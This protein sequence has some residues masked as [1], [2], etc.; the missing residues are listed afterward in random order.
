[1]ACAITAFS[2]MP[3]NHGILTKQTDN[4][5]AKTIALIDTGVSK[6]QKTVENISVI[7]KSPYDD[8]SHG[9]S[10]YKIIKKENPDAK[11]LSIKALNK[12]GEGS[13]EDV[14][15]AI[16]IAIDKKVDIINLSMA[17]VYN[18]DNK[19]FVDA[20][21]KASNSGIT[22]VMAA[23]NAGRPVSEYVAGKVDNDVIVVG[24]CEKNAES[25][26]S[27]FGKEIDYYVLTDSTSPAT[28]IISGKLSKGK[29]AVD[30][31][32]IYSDAKIERG[33]KVVTNNYNLSVAA[34]Y[35]LLVKYHVNG[36]TIADNPHNNTGGCDHYSSYTASAVKKY[37]FKTSSSLVTGSATKTGTYATFQGRFASTTTYINLHNVGTFG[38]SRTGYHITGTSA[39]RT[40]STGGNLINQDYSSSSTTNAATWNRLT[41][42]AAS[43]NKT[44]TLYVNWI[45]DSC[46]VT[47]NKNGGTGGTASVTATYNSN[48]PSATMPTRAGYKFEGYYD[49]AT[50]G[51]QYYTAAGA[52]ARTWNKAGTGGKT[53]YARWTPNTY[54]VN[55]NAN[56]GSGTMADQ[57]VTY[58]SG[59]TSLNSNTFTKTGYNFDGWAISYDTA[60]GKEYRKVS[61]GADIN[62]DLANAT[63]DIDVYALWKSKTV[64]DPITYDNYLGFNFSNDIEFKDF[65]LDDAT[66]TYLDGNGNTISASNSPFKLSHTSG[67]NAAN[68]YYNGPINF[69]TGAAPDELGMISV[70]GSIV[71]RFP[72]AAVTENGTKCDVIVKMTDV[73][74]YA[75]SFIDA[76]A[77][78]YDDND[79]F[80]V[81]LCY[82]DPN[83]GYFWSASSTVNEDATHHTYADVANTFKANAYN[84]KKFEVDIVA[85]SRSGA[86]LAGKK[87]V[88]GV[89][90]IDSL[91]GA[92][93][94]SSEGV[95]QG[96]ESESI[97]L[98]DNFDSTIFAASHDKYQN[99]DKQLT[100][101]EGNDNGP[102]GGT[103]V[104]VDPRFYENNPDARIGNNDEQTYWSGV[105]L[106]TTDSDFSFYS[107]TSDTSS[108]RLFE[109]PHAPIT[110]SVTHGIITDNYGYE[111]D[112]TNSVMSLDTALKVDGSDVTYNYEPEPGYH[113]ES[114]T[115]TVGTNGVTG[116]SSTPTTTDITSSAPTSTTFNGVYQNPLR[117]VDVDGSGTADDYSLGYIWPNSYALDVVYDANEFTIV[118]DKNATNATGTMADQTVD[119]ADNTPIR[120]NA[121]SRPGYR[122]IG[123]SATA[124]NA[125]TTNIGVVSSDPTAGR[126][127]IDGAVP[128]HGSTVTLKAQWEKLGLLTVSKDVVS[129][130][131]SDASLDFTFTVDLD[132]LEANETYDLRAD[133]SVTDAVL[134]NVQTD[135]NGTA[136]VTFTL[137]DGAS[138]GLLLPPGTEY[139][140]TETEN[141]SFTTTSTNSSG[142]ISSTADDVT[143]VFTNTRKT[144]NIR[145][146]KHVSSN[147]AS[148]HSSSKKFNF[149]VTL[150]ETS[151]TKECNGIQFTNGVSESIA[152]ADGE[153]INITG[154]PV[155]TTY[156]VTESADS[157]F[158][159]TSTNESGTVSFDG[160]SVSF[161]N[162]RKTGTLTLRKQVYND[163][164][165]L[166]YTLPFTFTITLGDNTFN[167]TI[168]GVN[169]VNGVATVQRRASQGILTIAGLPAGIS[170]TVTEQ[171]N[172]N[173][174]TTQTNATGTILAS[175]IRAVSFAN[176][177]DPRPGNLIIKKDIDYSD[178]YQEGM[179][180]QPLT[181]DPNL[182]NNRDYRIKVTLDNTSY[183]VYPFN[184]GVAYFTVKG[185]DSGS[186]ANALNQEI[187]TDIPIGTKY[188]VEEVEL[189][190]D[191]HLKDYFDI[192]YLKNPTSDLEDLG[193]DYG[194]M[195]EGTSGNNGTITTADQTIV[196]VNKPKLVEVKV[197][198]KADILYPDYNPNFQIVNEY[199]DY[200]GVLLEA[201]SV[202]N[203]CGTEPD[204]SYEYTE[205]AVT[206]VK[207]EA[208]FHVPAIYYDFN[209]DSSANIK[210][211]ELMTSYGYYPEDDITTAE[212]YATINLFE[213]E[214]PGPYAEGEYINNY[215]YMD[216]DSTPY[217]DSYGAYCLTNFNNATDRA[218]QDEPPSAYIT[219]VATALD[220]F[221][222]TPFGSYLSTPIKMELNDYYVFIYYKT[223]DGLARGFTI[224]K[225]YNDTPIDI[226]F[227]FHVYYYTP[228]VERYKLNNQGSFLNS[229][230]GNRLNNWFTRYSDPTDLSSAYNAYP[231]EL[232]PY[233]PDPEF[234]T[235]TTD[236]NNNGTQ[237][238]VIPPATAPFNPTVMGYTDLTSSVVRGLLS[239]D[240][241]SWF[242]TRTAPQQTYLAFDGNIVRSWNADT[243]QE[244]RNYGATSFL[245]LAEFDFEGYVASR[246]GVG[247]V[248]RY[249]NVD[250]IEN[251]PHTF[252]KLQI[253]K[254]E[255][256]TNAEISS[257]FA[258]RIELNSPEGI[259]ALPSEASNESGWKYVHPDGV[260]T[261]TRQ[262]GNWSY[263]FTVNG[264][265]YTTD[266][267]VYSDPYGISVIE[268]V[269]PEGYSIN[270]TPQEDREHSGITHIDV[271]YNPFWPGLT[272]P[273]YYNA[274]AYWAYNGDSWYTAEDNDIPNNYSSNNVIEGNFD[275]ELLEYNAFTN[276]YSTQNNLKTITFALVAEDDYINKQLSDHSINPSTYNGQLAPD[277]CYGTCTY[278]AQTDEIFCDYGDYSD[279]WSIME[280]ATDNFQKPRK[281]YLVPMI[282]T[283]DANGISYAKYISGYHDDFEKITQDVDPAADTGVPGL[284]TIRPISLYAGDYYKEISEIKQDVEAQMPNPQDMSISAYIQRFVDICQGDQSL[285]FRQ[286][287][288]DDDYQMA[289]SFMNLQDVGIVN[290]YDEFAPHNIQIS[291]TVT[292]EQNSL[293]TFPT[294]IQITGAKPN[295]TYSINYVTGGTGQAG[296]ITTDTN[297]AGSGTVNLGN[298]TTVTVLNVPH[299]AKYKVTETNGTYLP[300]VGVKKGT[301]GWQ[302]LNNSNTTSGITSLVDANGW[303]EL[304][305]DNQVQFTNNKQINIT[306]NKSWTDKNGA[307]L[308]DD[309]LYENS[310]VDVELYREQVDTI[311]SEWFNYPISFA[312]GSSYEVRQIVLPPPYTLL[313]TTNID[314][315]T[316]TDP[317]GIIQATFTSADIDGHNTVN[318]RNGYVV[319]YCGDGRFEIATPV[320]MQAYHPPVSGIDVTIQFINPVEVHSNRSAV[321]T[322]TLND[323]NSWSTTFNNLI[324]SDGDTSNYRYIV[325]EI[326]NDNELFESAEEEYLVPSTTT[327][328]ASV[329]VENKLK[330][331]TPN[332]DPSDG[333]ND[334]AELTKTAEVYDYEN[335]IYNIDLK[336][337]SKAVRVNGDIN[338][339]FAQSDIIADLDDQLDPAFYAVD[340]NGVPLE[341]GDKINLDGSRRTATD[342]GPYGIYFGDNLIKWQNQRIGN[343]A[344]ADE[345]EWHGRVFAKAKEDFMGGNTINTNEG[346]ALLTPKSVA[347]FDSNGDI[348]PGTSYPLDPYSNQVKASTP[349]VNV[350]E[351]LMTEENPTWQFVLND[352]VDGDDLKDQLENLLKDVKVKQVVTDDGEMVYPSAGGTA[353]A[354]SDNRESSI[355]AG[356]TNATIDLSDIIG[357][358]TSTQLE[359][360]FDGGT[361]RIPYSYE[362]HA[363]GQFEI[364]LSKLP[365]TLS[366]SDHPVTT[367]D[368]H[369]QISVTY[370]PTVAQSSTE[371]KT[372]NETTGE[373]GATTNNRT[374]NNMHTNTA[375]PLNLQ[376]LKR[377]GTTLAPITSGFDFNLVDPANSSNVITGSAVSNGTKT[378]SNIPTNT[379]G[380]WYVNEVTTPTGFQQIPNGTIRATIS[381]GSTTTTYP[382]SDNGVTNITSSPSITLSDTGNTYI[383]SSTSSGTSTSGTIHNYEITETTFTLEKNWYNS[384]E[385][386]MGLMQS[387]NPL[388]NPSVFDSVFDVTVTAPGNSTKTITDFV[389]NSE[390]DIYKTVSNFNRSYNQT[391]DE[392]VYTFK[393]RMS[394]PDASLSRTYDSI[395]ITIPI[396][397]KVQVTENMSAYPDDMLVI[398]EYGVYVRGA[399]PLFAYDSGNVTPEVDTSIEELDTIQ[400]S[401]NAMT[402]NNRSLEISKELPVGTQN[403]GDEFEFEIL[404]YYPASETEFAP[405]SFNPL[406]ITTDSTI[407][408]VIDNVNPIRSAYTIDA[409]GLWAEYPENPTENPTILHYPDEYPDTDSYSYRKIELLETADNSYIDIPMDAEESADL[410]LKDFAGQAISL[411]FK[412]KAGEHLTLDNLPRNSYAIIGEKAKSGWVSSFSGYINGDQ[413]NTIEAMNTEDDA[414]LWTSQVSPIEIDEIADGN[415]TWANMHIPY[416][417]PELADGWVNS[418]DT[419][420]FANG[421]SAVTFTNALLEQPVPRHNLTIGKNVTGNLGDIS[422]AFNMT[423][424]LTGLEPNATYQIVNA[425]DSPNNYYITPE[426]GNQSATSITA[427]SNGEINDLEFWI[428]D[429]GAFTIQG[430]PEN[431]TVTFAE[432]ANNH[433]PHATAYYET[434]NEDTDAIIP[435]EIVTA[436]NPTSGF[437]LELQSFELE[438][439]TKIDVTNLRSFRTVTGLNDSMMLLLMLIGIVSTALVAT[440]VVTRKRKKHFEA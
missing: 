211:R 312:G 251:D 315:I 402:N 56:G 311:T 210:V 193:Q 355:P 205:T 42:A 33:D 346:D 356:T 436:N 10:M 204:L 331:K 140:I 385:Y 230:F 287:V 347:D 122:F 209:N 83:G 135:S 196:V 102:N 146:E 179:E 319:S 391:N 36:G 50:G 380:Y 24:N 19:C 213:D 212:N 20:V 73:K 438:H 274:I 92:E 255:D 51:T 137:R 349:Y 378:F 40:A 34:T 199:L 79:D 253:L 382:G 178:F 152:L 35:Y 392:T 298:G 97:E 190:P 299:A 394:A 1:M 175:G 116:G 63:G 22:V 254:Y 71:M 342:T 322:E 267:L 114:V 306:V 87:A 277:I 300:R 14:A 234:Y 5:N 148:D 374:S 289:H 18:K 308:Q 364:K 141:N 183:N 363:T 227:P 358:L 295:T 202:D 409:F 172:V 290:L 222:N 133:T 263:L 337:L 118:Y 357:D 329:V 386:I 218:V 150:G 81:R 307:P 420:F 43:A 45:A 345:T 333:S 221:D 288:L 57:T 328:Q 11:I 220:E 413:N 259:V 13:P 393:V 6:S 261:A 353:N 379:S 143:S 359:T 291:K 229:T 366:L 27:N 262:G 70:P 160:S 103:L 158:T 324:L 174:T 326:S 46:T 241:I 171:P 412:L 309:T 4:G 214:Q 186:P 44:I 373:P 16:N 269:P 3:S 30:N 275:P 163:V 109:Q 243:G 31:K 362:G 47:L 365:T 142:T 390:L 383:A 427:D 9:A 395:D 77:N 112:G 65:D 258:C 279:F 405:F 424:T 98:I 126:A 350:N 415:P 332:Y 17:A 426:S 208:V 368:E 272:F 352:V 184:N 317:A 439:D 268:T 388:L 216:E 12:H 32:K 192:S 67:T 285:V 429:D 338:P 108:T 273:Y 286:E 381:D 293:Q 235:T 23:G 421:D 132:G 26:F 434:I 53:L 169:F 219:D 39:Y 58:N 249:P 203:V 60:S 182:Y 217:P 120:T 93:A 68:I 387:E 130:N 129:D 59:A 354:T 94:Y 187:I 302:Y 428:S 431:A 433:I 250:Y 256:G 181:V 375:T 228:S 321:R 52:S 435:H 206:N 376:L 242:S 232:I 159:T 231:Q 304:T 80:Y 74:V 37:Y 7:G 360:V 384:F 351:L 191:S 233:T 54:T 201:V 134:S 316:I 423:L 185:I 266:S 138:K 96:E 105:V 341:F 99:N 310:S 239:S 280:A 398:P 400:F 432:E 115:K 91:N 248:A 8:H 417:D 15:K 2:I 403:S 303:I 75:A 252:S 323:D 361:V 297:G 348:V 55:Y 194:F 369:Y 282:V 168:N 318:A 177:Y 119:F 344:I 370:R 38:I 414:E 296:T 240:V 397:S 48:M 189:N 76:N 198:K 314:E 121:F 343:T 117:Y 236:E 111:L 244:F 215:G 320:S 84:T 238:S 107:T 396:N 86:G 49:A 416:E 197:N 294:T 281:M 154:L 271:G 113:L 164:D 399:D 145:I 264:T 265:P 418:H 389:P 257:D 301:A 90:D 149:T 104:R 176:I 125:E 136:S 419:I 123:W 406:V 72:N 127:A 278:D 106:A 408:E 335:R 165:N 21:N 156:Q 340:E 162:T 305:E 325:K 245:P 66:I 161:T 110:L 430:L 284:N 283:Y 89:T 223:T 188:T 336:A 147:L 69:G 372:G 411:N 29:V 82:T 25:G 292:G 180:S 207:G 247:G 425:G 377:N 422:K 100:F 173:F 226:G 313:D 64:N 224:G 151:F 334:N 401:N 95:F 225:N 407:R 440:I 78:G 367:T 371:Y 437:D 167:G 270:Q 246:S 62:A 131:A 155:G 101:I 404:L 153:S 260:V 128:G 237:A 276:N 170:Y 166:N 330:T 61:N 124:D 85:S 139:E 327:N 195:Y 157:N 144:G 200:S 28:A 41:G 410:M 339:S 88:W